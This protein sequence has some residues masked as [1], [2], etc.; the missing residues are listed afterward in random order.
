L[1]KNMAERVGFES[2]MKPSFKDIKSTDGIQNSHRAKRR[3][4]SASQ[5]RERLSRQSV[6]A[7]LRL[8]IKTLEAKNRELAEMLE[9]AYGV[10]AE[11]KVY[12]CRMTPEW[13]VTAKSPVLA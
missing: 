1:L 2:V 3:P 4:A 8:R 7:T 5:D 6:V 9:R 11:P 12:T 10:I 13:P